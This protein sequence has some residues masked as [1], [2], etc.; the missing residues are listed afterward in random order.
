MVRTKTKSMVLRVTSFKVQNVIADF[1][2]RVLRA[3]LN[4]FS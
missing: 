2:T 3:Q 4:M 1:H